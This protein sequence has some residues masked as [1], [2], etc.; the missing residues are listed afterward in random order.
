MNTCLLSICFH[1][2][3]ELRQK[4]SGSALAKACA[5]QSTC[6]SFPIYTVIKTRGQRPYSTLTHLFSPKP[7]LVSWVFFETLYNFIK[8]V[9]Y[10]AHFIATYIEKYPINSFKC[11]PFC[12][13]PGFRTNKR[14][15]LL[16][17]LVLS[18]HLIISHVDLQAMKYLFGMGLLFRKV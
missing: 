15:I 16:T 12:K 5:Y 9:W 4:L 13:I 10:I 17:K 8:R 6:N 7:P 18:A 1:C 11:H 14:F 2:T 3:V